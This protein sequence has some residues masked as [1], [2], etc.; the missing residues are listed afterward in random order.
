MSAIFCDIGGHSHCRTSPAW[1]VL[2][3]PMADAPSR[4][5]MLRCTPI[6][7]E[8]TKPQYM[9]ARTH[10]LSNTGIQSDNVQVC[11]ETQV[12]K[13]G[14]LGCSHHCTV[15]WKSSH[16]LLLNNSRISRVASRH[17]HTHKSPQA[18]RTLYIPHGVDQDEERRTSPYSHHR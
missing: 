15:R 14:V 6:A 8:L 12:P 4:D 3:A 1:W 7:A 17:T 2:V 18:Q 10:G 5:V 16:R 13:R 9:N 11:A